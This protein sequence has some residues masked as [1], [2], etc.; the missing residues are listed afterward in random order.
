MLDLSLDDDKSFAWTSQSQERKQLRQDRWRVELHSK[1]LGVHHN[2]CKRFGNKS[3]QQR[4]KA[5]EPLWQRLRRCSS[6]VRLKVAALP[7]LAWLGQQSHIW[8][9]SISIRCAQV[10]SRA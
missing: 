5:M 1:V 7:V 6:P 3:L 4:V 8:A 10:R 9:N 2:F